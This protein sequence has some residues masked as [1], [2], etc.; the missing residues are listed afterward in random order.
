MSWI[1][2]WRMRRNCM[3]HRYRPGRGHESWI[4]SRLINTRTGKMF[5]CIKCG[6]VWIV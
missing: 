5:W 2:R 3:H 1:K 6:K 4:E